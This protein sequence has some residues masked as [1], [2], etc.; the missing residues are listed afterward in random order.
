MEVELGRSKRARRAYGFDEVALVPGRVTI[1]PDEIEIGL[2]IDGMSLDIPFLAAAMDGVVDVGFAVEMGR[3]GGLAVLN[4]D[5]VQCRYEDP[6]EV[7]AEIAA[8]PVDEVNV[9]LQRI[10]RA[11]VQDGLIGQRI[12]DIKKGG[13]S[14]AVSTVPARAE[15]RAGIVQEAGADCLVVQGTVLTARHVSRAHQQLSFREL[16]SQLRI[17][18]VVGN[19][20]DYATAL[21]LMDTGIK[22]L[23]V[24]VGPGAACTT[25]AVLGVGVPQ[26]TAT[27]DCAA[28][29]DDH[30]RRSGERVA[31][32]TDGGMRLG[33]DVAKAL[34]SGADAVMIG[35]VFASAREA[36]GR[37]NHW[38][39]ATPDPNLPRGTRIRT[40]VK[41]SL[42]EIL[43]GPAHV[44]DGSMNLVGAL[45][46]AMGVCGARTIADFQETE[47]VIA[48]A[49]KTEGKVQQREQRVGMGI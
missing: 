32:I 43:F 14:C 26:V 35:S 8:A 1:D 45:K 31:V 10:Y 36:A 20:V 4:L 42:E 7:L 19:C 27:S 40:G 25:R 6:A 3:L 13:G 41:G 28:A 29:R 23:L 17:P 47:M 48:P 37:G 44:D 30:L 16:T 49:I 5:G 18:V 2:S 12:E 24:G 33:G 9:L 46:S 39:M 34:A 22:G 21:E 15:R 38:G 11:P